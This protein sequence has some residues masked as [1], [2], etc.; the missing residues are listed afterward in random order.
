MDD[1]VFGGKLGVECVLVEDWVAE[2]EDG[3]FSNDAVG[4]V[5]VGRADVVDIVRG[6]SSGAHIGQK[7]GRGEN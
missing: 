7:Y 4:V 3:G 5:T 1:V 2:V 6:I